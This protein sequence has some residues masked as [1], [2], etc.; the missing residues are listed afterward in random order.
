MALTNDKFDLRAFLHKIEDTEGTDAV[1]APGANAILL[2]NGE[3]QIQDDDLEREIDQPAGGA[4][5]RVKVRRRGTITGG[6]ELLGNA[7]AGSASPFSSLLRAAGHT[8][9]LLVA[10]PGPP[11]VFDAAQY[12]PILKNIP[13]AS[14]YF[15]HDGEF[16]QLVGSRSRLTSA[17]MEINGIPSADTET[18]GKV[19]NISE[20]DVPSGVDFSAF[21]EPIVGTEDTTTGSFA[22][23]SVLLD[24]VALD[25]ISVSVDFGVELAMRYSTEAT[26][27]LH[28]A[29]AVTGTLTI[30][31]P[32]VAT[33]DIRSMVAS[34]AQVPLIVDYTHTDEARTQSWEFPAVQ[35]DEPRL[36]NRDGDKAWEVGFVALPTA[37]N[38]DYTLT[39]GKRPAT[40]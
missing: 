1:P 28:R 13:S 5:P 18:L 38:D 22:D 15:Y 3:V 6:I 36:V 17:T 27:A 37:G 24:G 7:T 9:T 11:E 32:E 12:N 29:R 33:S 34:R 21:P 25:G 16:F 10:D 40:V 23:M 14:S 20:A 30:F 31:R 35:L 39:F 4:K 19:L 26:R 8:E 2:L